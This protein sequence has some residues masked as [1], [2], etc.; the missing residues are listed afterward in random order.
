MSD[1]NASLAS[2]RKSAQNVLVSGTVGAGKTTA[3]KTL[4]DSFI[5]DNNFGEQVFDCGELKITDTE[6]VFLYAF[7]GLNNSEFI[8]NY[9]NNEVI[10]TILLIDNRRKDPLRDLESLLLN[11]YSGDQSQILPEQFVIGITHFD[12]SRTPAVSDYH[13][14]LKDL[15]FISQQK[16]PI[17]SVDT[18]AFHDVSTLM[19]ALVYTRAPTINVSLSE[20]KEY[21]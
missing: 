18:R 21:Q 7:N 4:S 9:L 6:S 5:I 2:D 3:I 10:G 12:T 8:W 19:E 14:F 1:E 11:L 13:S 15:S 20:E 17:F 16:T